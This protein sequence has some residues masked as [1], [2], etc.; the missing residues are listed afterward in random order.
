M[1]I[2]AL[3]LVQHFE[4]V[5]ALVQINE[6]TLAGVEEDAHN[7]S[8]KQGGLPLGFVALRVNG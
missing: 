2:A 3:E 1:F 6:S 5:R 7:L 8:V 4:E